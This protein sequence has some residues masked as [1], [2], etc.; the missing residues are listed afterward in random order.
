MSI[1]EAAQLVEKDQIDIL[2]EI[3]GH[4]R[5][6]CLGV[7]GIKPAPVQVD[8]GGIDTSGMEQIDYR[9][10]DRLMTPVHMDRFYVEESVCLPGGIYSYRPPRSSP[11]VG[12]LPA[13]RNNYPTYASFSNSVKINPF[14][15][16]LW[17][18]ILN[19]DA[20]SRFILKFFGGNE[21][22]LQEYYSGELERLGICR[23]RVDFYDM[24]SSHFVHMN[25]YNEVDI[26]LDTCPFSG[27][28][29][30]MEALW[31]GVPTI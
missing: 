28:M 22:G 13:K 18:R 24:F 1:E 31:M 7:M 23:E 27:C 6:N 19:A 8:Y 5:D 17:A 15:M 16:E 9:L 3:G 26:M 2:I 29:T 25:L 21:P 12:P 4:C 10:T 14:T 11:L 20:N 30:T